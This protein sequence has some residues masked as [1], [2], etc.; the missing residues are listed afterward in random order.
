M[1]VTESS[2]WKWLPGMRDAYGAR[3]CKVSLHDGAWSCVL[4]REW[5]EYHYP[6][7][8]D[9]DDPATCGAIVFGIFEP[10]GI[11]IDKEGDDCDPG[12]VVFVARM[13]SRLVSARL[14]VSKD[15]L[16][17][18]LR[19]GTRADAIRAVFAA[20]DSEAGR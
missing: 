17:S 12:E 18:V 15:S 20:L 6:T 2:A 9:L 5:A 19:S 11:T 3:L 7:E 10:L 8:P 13:P 16:W 1:S 14:F 4:G